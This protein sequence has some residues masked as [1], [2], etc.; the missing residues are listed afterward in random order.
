MVLYGNYIWAVVVYVHNIRLQDCPCGLKVGSRL[1]FL[2]PVHIFPMCIVILR[3]P[4]L[5]WPGVGWLFGVS[6]GKGVGNRSGGE[7]GGI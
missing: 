7:S 3:S 5:L 1:Y 2:L 4:F 6:M